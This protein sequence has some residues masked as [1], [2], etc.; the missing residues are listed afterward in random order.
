MTQKGY[1]AR[2]ILHPAYICFLFAIT[3]IWVM[4][5]QTPE[6]SVGIENF[7]KINDNYYRGGQPRQVDLLQLK[8][9]GVK[10]VID[11]RRDSE[12]KEAEW[13]RSS[14]M[15]YFN[16]PL[17][18][19]RPANAEQTAYFLR[20]VNDTQNWPVYVHCK[21]GRHRTGAMTA[22]YRIT[23]DRWTA[24]Q[25]Y[26]EMKEYDFNHGVLGGPAAQKNYV[27]S[28]Y[29]NYSQRPGR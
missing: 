27:Y 5:G 9:L 13:V 29:Q 24:D 21:G 25:A 16:I 18:S 28:F 23:H 26:R 7:G 12:P 2:K 17:Q 20:L 22:I 15:R 19:S 11:L 14:G 8:K 6:R 4:A 10:T 3:V 1:S